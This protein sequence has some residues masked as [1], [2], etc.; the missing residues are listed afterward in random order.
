MG[1]L[2]QQVKSREMDNQTRLL[3]PRVAWA[4]TV[5]QALGR[6][7]KPGSTLLTECVRIRYSLAR[8]MRPHLCAGESPPLRGMPNRPSIE[9]GQR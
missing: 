5:G 1:S 8:L 9:G 4:A 7:A 3:A 6:A 2:I